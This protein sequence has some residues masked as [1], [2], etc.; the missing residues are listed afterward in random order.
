MEMTTL[1]PENE[2]DY[3]ISDNAV[4]NPATELRRFIADLFASFVRFFSFLGYS[5]DF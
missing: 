4:L 5:I 2:I 3:T 1:I